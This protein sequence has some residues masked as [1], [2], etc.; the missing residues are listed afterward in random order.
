[1]ASRIVS[2]VTFERSCL[3][4]FRGRLGTG[5]RQS[6]LFGLMWKD[7]DLAAN[8]LSVRR[9]LSVAKN[10]PAFTTPK[11]NKSRSVRLTPGAVEA[12]HLHRKRQLRAETD[13]TAKGSWPI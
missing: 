3:G 13:T 5:L 7:V 9:I 10:G 4:I 12:L 6:E 2:T 8:R 1:M 11:N